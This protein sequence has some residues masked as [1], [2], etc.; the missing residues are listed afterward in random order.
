M[1]W[2]VANR[3]CISDQWPLLPLRPSPAGWLAG[4]PSSSGRQPW[5]T[6]QTHQR[7]AAR[8]FSLASAAPATE[9][10]PSTSTRGF[11][12]VTRHR[13]MHVLRTDYSMGYASV[14]KMLLLSAVGCLSLLNAGD[15]GS[16]E[17]S[18]DR[19]AVP[20]GSLGSRP[21]SPPS[22]AWGLVTLV[23]SFGHGYCRS[24]GARAQR[25]HPG[26]PISAGTS[27]R[28][29]RSP[30]QAAPRIRHPLWSWQPVSCS[31]PNHPSCSLETG[32]RRDPGETPQTGQVSFPVGADSPS[33][34]EG[35]LGINSCWRRASESG[36]TMRHEVL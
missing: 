33:Y 30:L 28:A 24:I 21:K 9:R 13:D 22:I 31:V 36:W 3:R 5:G 19:G 27:S 8:H 34:G 6:G 10:P 4:E 7:V 17:I 35:V 32:P 12:T 23:P 15:N 29:W 20:G 11:C 26:P 16:I 18:F 1:L 25:W 14:W 2:Y